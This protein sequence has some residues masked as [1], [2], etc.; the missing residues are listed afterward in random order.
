MRLSVA[1]IAGSLVAWLASEPFAYTARVGGTV[2]GEQHFTLGSFFGWFAHG[3]FG[4]CTIGSMAAVMSWPRMRPGMALLWGGA[5]FLLG[6]L[7]GWISDREAD[8]ISISMLRNGGSGFDL[9]PYVLWSFMVAMAL[10]VALALSSQPTG[11]R[12]VRVLCGGVVAGALGFVVRL[13]ILPLSAIFALMFAGANGHVV[14]FYPFDPERLIDY[15]VMAVALGV[16]LGLA[17]TVF[18]RASLR[19]VLGRNEQREYPLG[20]GTSRIGSAEGIEVP[21]FGDP[22]IRP[23]HAV[24]QTQ[25]S[26]YWLQEGSAGASITVNGVPATNQRLLPGDVVGIG[27]QALV[28]EVRGS[29]AR[30]TGMPPWPARDAEP[31]NEQPRQ[32]PQYQPQPHAGPR[33]LGKF[34]QV[35]PLLPGSL[36]VG[37]EAGCAVHLTEDLSVSRRHARLEVGQLGVTLADLG[38]SNGTFVNGEPVTVPRVLIDGDEL[39]FGTVVLR[40]RITDQT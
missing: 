16:S 24:V 33:L 11:P 21:I 18:Q 6:G 36:E 25:E 30:G 1:G 14:S 40:F 19:L 32:A 29:H 27:G 34:G 2:V 8:V 35:F 20:A 37:R 13:A 38:S 28:F 31:W 26:G 3:M 23:V 4:A 12:V 17:E 7:G 10:A 5:G 22:S 39:R 15:A 9:S